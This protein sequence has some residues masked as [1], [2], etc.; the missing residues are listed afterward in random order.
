LIWFLTAS[1]VRY[2]VNPVFCCLFAKLFPTAIL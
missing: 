1:F 2:A